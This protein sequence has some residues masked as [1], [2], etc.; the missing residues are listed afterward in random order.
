MKTVAVFFGGDSPER[1]ISIITGMLAVNL[2][3]GSRYRAI[4]VYLP[5]EGGM[6]R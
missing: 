2:L 6:V 4:P 3:R 1:E 5:P